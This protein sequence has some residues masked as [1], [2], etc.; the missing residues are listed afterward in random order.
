TSEGDRASGAEAR[1]ERAALLVSR[2]EQETGVERVLGVRHRA[3]AIRVAHPG[4]LDLDDLRAEIRHHRRRRRPRD[5]ARAIDDLEPVENPFR[6]H[7]I[8]Y[9]FT[10]R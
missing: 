10:M 7:L 2:V 3:P 1:M 4:R 8:P 9:L 6:H 5:E